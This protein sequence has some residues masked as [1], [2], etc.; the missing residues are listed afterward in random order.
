VAVI[1][2]MRAAKG[3]NQLVTVSLD[4]GE[5]LELT[6]DV[7]VEKRLKVGQS[8]LESVVQGL[9]QEDR[10]QRCYTAAIR[11]LS[12]RARSEAEVRLK[13]RQRSFEADAIER[14]ISRLRQQG[15][16]DDQAFAH[17]WKDSRQS[18][19]PRSGMMVKRELRQ[20]GVSAE[21]AQGVASEVDD[22]EAA[23]SAA[24]KRALR[25]TALDW[26]GFQRLLGGYLRRRGFSYEV[27]RKTVDR[28]WQEKGGVPGE[29]DQE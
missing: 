28:V 8:L 4:S 20:K 3:R 5:A 23:F 9:L 24:R 17:Y 29:H 26:T 6:V 12:Y 13:L 11:S 18:I 10:A 25:L 15:L 2:S 21:V 7:V 16:V 14:A 22:D 27:A 19:R 1:T